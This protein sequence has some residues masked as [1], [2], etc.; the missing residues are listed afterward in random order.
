MPEVGMLAREVT[1]ELIR[2][3]HVRHEAYTAV[4]R[5]FEARLVAPTSSWRPIDAARQQTMYLVGHEAFRG[6]FEV[7]EYQ[8]TV[9]WVH[10]GTSRRLE[11]EPT[12]F[13]EIEPPPFTHSVNE[14]GRA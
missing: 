8:I 10:R 5:L 7:A 12:H 6:W 9:G 4:V 13:A 2:A 1:L 14:V 3:G 11:H